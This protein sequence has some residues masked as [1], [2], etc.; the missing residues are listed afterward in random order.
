MEPRRT[1]AAGLGIAATSGCSGKRPSEL[2]SDHWSRLF[3][4]LY[5]ITGEE[6]CGLKVVDFRAE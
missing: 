2:S 5:Q 4:C 3:P 1:H 6:M